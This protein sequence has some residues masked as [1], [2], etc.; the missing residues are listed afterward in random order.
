MVVVAEMD[1]HCAAPFSELQVDF[2]GEHLGS[3]ASELKNRQGQRNNVVGVK[4]LSIIFSWF[5][6]TET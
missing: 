2:F 1:R 6:S 5:S 3:F 4:I